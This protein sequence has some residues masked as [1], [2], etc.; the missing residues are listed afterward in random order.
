MDSSHPPSLPL[1]YPPRSHITPPSIFPL[2]LSPTLPFS[3][4]IH[5]L[6]PPPSTLPTFHPSH[7]PSSPPSISPTLH[8]LHPPY[9]PSP[10][11]PLL[12]FP[13]LHLLPLSISP[14]LPT[15]PP[16]PLPSPYCLPLEEARSQGS[17]GDIIYE[18]S[19]LVQRACGM[20]GGIVG[21]RPMPSPQ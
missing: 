18:V 5:P 9:T 1:P 2:S 20:G 4:H 11:S 21:L 12:P 8:S 17:P 3:P 19:L 15:L 13:T 14:T 6:S 7:P 10:V 16:Y